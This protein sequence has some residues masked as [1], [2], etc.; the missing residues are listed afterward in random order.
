MTGRKHKPLKGVKRSLTCLGHGVTLSARRRDKDD[1][2]NYRSGG[3]CGAPVQGRDQISQ[4]PTS[5]G[6][7]KHK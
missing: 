5:A 4:P 1:V 6:Y 3:A 2:D 7:D